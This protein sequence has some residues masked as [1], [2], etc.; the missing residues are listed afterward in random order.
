[1]N[2]VP[3]DD[4]TVHLAKALVGS[5]VTDVFEEDEVTTILFETGAKLIIYDAELEEES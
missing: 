3:V 2:K 5:M 1:M 4:T